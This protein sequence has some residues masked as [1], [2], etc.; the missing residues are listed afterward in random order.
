MR[1][2]H[3]PTGDTSG[4]A[5]IFGTGHGNVHRVTLTQECCKWCW[6]QDGYQLAENVIVARGFIREQQPTLI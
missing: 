4:W 3:H 2:N 6:F 5:T 1:I